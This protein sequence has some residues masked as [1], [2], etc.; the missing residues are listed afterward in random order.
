MK[1]GKSRA[2][3]KRM[4]LKLQPFTE[5]VLWIHGEH[6][7]ATK[8]Q[9]WNMLARV[10][11]TLAIAR[12]MLNDDPSP[13]PTTTASEADGTAS[14]SRQAELPWDTAVEAEPV[15]DASLRGAASSGQPLH[16][17]GER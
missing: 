2:G 13:P 14:D 10:Q 9:L 12:A 5:L 11:T 16:V 6:P 3:E 8:P 17:S 1:S 4:L 15:G 7:Y